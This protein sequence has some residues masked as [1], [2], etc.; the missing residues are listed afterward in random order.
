LA[1]VVAPSFFGQLQMNTADVPLAILLAL[2]L[3]ALAAWLRSGESGLLPAAALFLGAG[4]ITKPE[5][6]LFVLAAFVAAAVVATRGQLKALGLS[7]AAVLAVDLPWRIWTAVHHLK[8]T[9]YSLSDLFDAGYLRHQSYR[10]HPVVEELLYQVRSTGSWS[11]L[12]LLVVAGLAGALLLRRFRLFVFTAGWLVL[13]FA[14]LVGVYWISGDP[15]ANHLYNSADR[16]I[17]TL[18]IGPALLVPV[19]LA[20]PTDPG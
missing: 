8:S 4:A 11:Y 10:V 20:R 17:D 9:D 12:A 18:V 1:I 19:L 6:E 16:T 3:V 13:S 7:A 2:G 5:G 15:L 14:G